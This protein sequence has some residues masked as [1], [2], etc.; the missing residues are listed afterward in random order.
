MSCVLPSAPTPSHLGKYKLSFMDQLAAPI[1]VNIIFYYPIVDKLVDDPLVENIQRRSRMEKSLSETLTI[2]YP[3]AGRYTKG[4]LFVD[5]ND[6][7]VAY[8][9]AQVLN[10]ELAQVVY[11]KSELQLLNKF[12]PWNSGKVD[13]ATTPLVTIQ[14][15][16]FTCGGVAVCLRI[17]HRIADG[18]TIAAFATAW[19]TASRVGIDGVIQPSFN[20]ADHI[21]ARVLPAP[22]HPPSRKNVAKIVTRRFVFDGEA[23]STL[24][25]KLGCQT[26]RV[27]VV[28]A[29]IWKAFICLTLAKQGGIMAS[30]LEHAVNLRGRTVPPMPKNTF[31]NFIT[32]A[33]PRIAGSDLSKM[34]L[35]DLVKL[36]QN[37]VR[38]TTNKK[39]PSEDFFTM[40]SSSF[41]EVDEELNH[42]EVD[43]RMFTSWCR[44]PFYEA[45]F[46]WGKPCWVSSISMSLEIT[47]LIDTKDGDGIEAWVSLDEQDMLQFQQ[48]ENIKTFSS[49]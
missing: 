9:E 23:I 5:C 1:H 48:D 19:T 24:K 3:L 37:V 11:G 43:Y 8:L 35:H 15:N 14:V 16:S 2:F 30:I 29:V 38:S 10:C 21:P 27:E 12:V 7:G 42:N 45:D 26:S 46:G 44:F 20:L 17:S 39:L 4:D 36:I 31:A 28:T 47:I 49:Y 41:R 18:F 13:V 22:K 6:E 25:V 34:E 33:L 40:V 32:L